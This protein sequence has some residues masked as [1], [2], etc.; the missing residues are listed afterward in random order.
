MSDRGEEITRSEKEFT[1]GSILYKASKFWR[2]FQLPLYTWKQINLK[3]N[4]RPQNIIETE[5]KKALKILILNLS[6]AVL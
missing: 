3:K 2:Y 1:E 5:I 6:S 4:Y